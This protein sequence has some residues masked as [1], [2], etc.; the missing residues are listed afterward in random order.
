MVHEPFCQICGHRFE[1]IF[2]V[3]MECKVAKKAW[4]LTS[5]AESLNSM[6]G[7]DLLTIFHDLARKISRADFELMTIICWNIWKARNIFLFEAKKSDPQMLV[8]IA[9]ALMEAYQKVKGLKGMSRTI[10]EKKIRG[11]QPPPQNGFKVNVDVAISNDKQLS[12]LGVVIRDSVGKAIATAVKT[13][14][15]Y[16]D[17]AYAEAEAAN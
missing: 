12:V 3:L 5:F 9:G 17:V 11:W 6:T 14:K 8:I 1:N 10:K 13:T 7:S 16:G 4:R 15:F 2:H